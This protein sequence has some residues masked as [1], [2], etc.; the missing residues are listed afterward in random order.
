LVNKDSWFRSKIVVWFIN[1][2]TKQLR[3]IIGKT[4]YLHGPTCC[5]GKVYAFNSV[6]GN[7]KVLEIDI[8][9]QEKKVAR[10]L[11]PFVEHPRIEFSRFHRT[12]GEHG[13][14]RYLKGYCS[15]LFYI[16]IDFEDETS[17][18]VGDVHLYK[19][20]MSNMT[21]EKMEDLKDA[22]FFIQVYSQYPVY[23]SPVITPELAG[24]I[25]ILDSMGKQ[26]Y[27]YHVKNRTISIASMS[28]LIPTS[29][30]SSWGMLE[31]RYCIAFNEFTIPAILVIIPVHARGFFRKI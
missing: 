27:S 29:G 8:S 5:N 12:N 2:F 13:F 22:I 19:L 26:L 24:Y 21:W 11:L 10:R 17:E 31:C 25:H 23:Y 20:D 9:V 28:S 30:M 18:T 1:L 4:G 3:R 16:K 7:D 6:K 14:D 15:E